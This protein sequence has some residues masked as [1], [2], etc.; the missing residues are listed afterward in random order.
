MIVSAPLEG[1]AASVLTRAEA[2]VA[3]YAASGLSTAR[4][5]EHR[6]TSR[7]TVANQL[8]SSYAKLGVSSRRGLAAL[9]SS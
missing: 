5:A 9:L 8:A 1:V 4:I 6:R 2:E 3:R 7:T